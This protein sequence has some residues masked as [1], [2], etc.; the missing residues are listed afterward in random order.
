MKPRVLVTGASGFVG[1]AL[2]EHLVSRNASEVIAM[3]RVIPD[4]PVIGARY[5]PVGDLVLQTQWSSLLAGVDTLVHAAARVHILND[6]SAQSIDE[7]ER[8][9]VIPTLEMARHAAAM[10]VR[11][12][13]FLSSIGVNGVQTQSNIAFSETDTPNPHNAY[14]LSKLQAERGLHK[15]AA[16]TGLDV[17]I[18]RPPLV[19]GPGVRAN[20][21]ALMHAVQSGWPL[22]LGVVHNQRSLVALDNLIDFIATCIHHPEAANE[23]FLIS[24]GDDVSSAE[25]VRGLARAAG[26]S[27]RLLPVPAWVLWAGAVALGKREFIQ[28]L[29]GSLQVDITKART[30]LGWV[31]QISLDEGLRRAVAGIH[32]HE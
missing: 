10:G 12:F 2:V 1:R 18:I 30:R 28:R 14:A 7:F 13:I 29:C 6:R 25:L 16:Q 4:N 22:P 23:T 26:V 5:F 21:A 15:I 24:D 9:N 31:P 19:Y 20:F 8:V 11:R 27:A 3:T 32:T 17:V